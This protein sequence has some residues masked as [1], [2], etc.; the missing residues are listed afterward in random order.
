[1]KVHPHDLL[2]Q[3]LFSA[4][5]EDDQAVLD[6]VIR[7][8]RCQRRARSLL[9]AKPDPLV[10]KVV[11]LDLRLPQPADH[12]FAVER[13]LAR[14]SSLL[15]FYEEEK[16]EA[17]G[18]LPE[19]LEHP[20]GRRCWILRNHRRFQT[21]G[22]FE[23][24]LE[25]SRD[26]SFQDAA[27]AE[28]MALLALEIPDR[29]ED[30]DDERLED[31]RARALACV[32]NAR[33]VQSDLRGAEEAFSVAFSHLSRGTRDPMERA[34]LL[35]LKASLRRAQGRFTEAYRLLHRAVFLFR[36]LGERHLAG[37]SLVNMAIVLRY[38]GEPS[39]AIPL[40]HQALELIDPAREPRLLLFTW[41]NL[42]DDLAENG[43]FMEAQGLLARARPL[44]RQFPQPWIQNRRKWVEGR[45]ARGLGQ[46]GQAETLFL[47][48]R[49]GFLLEGAAYD[50]ALVSLD[51]AYFYAE[52]GRMAELKNVAE[53]MVP[54]FSSRQIHREALAALAFWRQ[55]VEAERVGVDLVMSVASFLKRARHDPEL[56][57]Q[58]PE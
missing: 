6:H 26:Q 9:H 41:N 13:S 50:T 24:L 58:Q 47:E 37:R 16:A 27:Q 53:E 48:A 12:T 38:A 30:F 23:L 42:I 33:R 49:D 21:W 17:V 8:G 32:G 43:Q 36:Q 29:L 4:S 44:Y 51:L 52:Q 19:L 7:C 39:R 46:R 31:M 28:E 20:A 40:L 57:F 22:L 54:I 15:A 1:M 10:D 56:R 18:L 25:R 45:I 5:G 14:A 35:D 11:W 2:I 3:E 55:A 34:V